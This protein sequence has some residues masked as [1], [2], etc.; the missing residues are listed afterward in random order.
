LAAIVTPKC[1][2]GEGGGV[3]ARA[4]EGE[5]EREYSMRLLA[6]HRETCFGFPGGADVTYNFS[7]AFNTASYLLI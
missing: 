6:I 1:I 4:R 7:Y 5:R 2:L 3:W